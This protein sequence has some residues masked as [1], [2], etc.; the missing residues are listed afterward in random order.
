MQVLVERGAHGLTHRS[1]DA[2]AG[3]PAGTTS[4]YFRTSAALMKAIAVEIPVGDNTFLDQLVLDETLPPEELLLG[5]LRRRLE[6]MV[7]PWRLPALAWYRLVVGG[8]PAPEMRDAVARVRDDVFDDTRK[9]VFSCG[10]TDPERHAR[11]LRSFIGSLL[12]V[13]YLHK[14]PTADLDPML[15]AMAR[16]MIAVIDRDAEGDDG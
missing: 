6:F 10:S 13:Q 8:I 9:I 11:M 16:G 14:V 15:V 7:G 4:N 2:K 3:V 1:V 5:W 12:L